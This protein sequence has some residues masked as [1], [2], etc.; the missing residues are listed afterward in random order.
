MVQEAER[1]AGAAT[2]GNQALWLVGGTAVQIHCRTA[3][4]HAR[5]SRRPA[6]IDVL[7]TGAGARSMVDFLR[8]A[9]YEPSEGF[10]ALNGQH[11]L[12]FFDRG[13]DRQLDVFVERFQMCHSI[14]LVARLN[15][16]ERGRV[17]P[18]AELLL[19]KLQ[20]VEIN[21]KDLDD[22]CNLL[23]HLP[24]DTHDRLAINGSV[25]AAVCAGDWGLWRTCTLNLQHVATVARARAASEDQDEQAIWRTV[26]IRVEEL[27][28]LIEAEPKSRSWRLRSLL[29]E[30][31]RW[32]EEPEE[33]GEAIP[34]TQPNNHVPGGS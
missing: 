26:E 16:K 17:L 21:Q 30:R 33:V 6:D 34:V 32:Y 3:E 1:L 19:M 18:A 11:R 7:T 20:V 10:N 2:A 8:D 23:A 31:V 12:L 28:G 29:G 15:G 9:G 24:V 13:N 27:T 4:G 14:P 22:I 25:V 5:F